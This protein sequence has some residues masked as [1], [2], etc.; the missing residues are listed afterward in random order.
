[1]QHLLEDS[2][3]FLLEEVVTEAKTEF[4]ALEEELIEALEL[5]KLE[6][7]EEALTSG[8]EGSD[9]EKAEE[10]IIGFEAL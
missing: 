2:S 1:L 6:L 10:R 9:I 3:S 4:E 7:L 5:F 8:K